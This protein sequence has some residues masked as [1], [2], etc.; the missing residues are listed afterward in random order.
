M[1]IWISV[2]NLIVSLDWVQFFERKDIPYLSI[3]VII[4]FVFSL[5]GATDKS[6]TGADWEY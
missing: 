2:W 6:G 1:S 3:V 4:L 5:V